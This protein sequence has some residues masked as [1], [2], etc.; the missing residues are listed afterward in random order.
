[1]LS[2]HPDPPVYLHFLRGIQL[3]L[4]LSQFDQLLLPEK[5]QF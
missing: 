3:L 4:Q 1:M 2:S 5:N